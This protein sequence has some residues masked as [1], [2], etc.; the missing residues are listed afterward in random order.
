MSVGGTSEDRLQVWK[1]AAGRPWTQLTWDSD[2]H[3][4]DHVIALGFHG[5]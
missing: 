1:A 2:L 4:G 3:C 5:L